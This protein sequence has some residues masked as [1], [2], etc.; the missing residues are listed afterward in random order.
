MHGLEYDIGMYTKLLYPKV[1]N[2]ACT[3]LNFSV[4]ECY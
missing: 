1:N 4:H 3:L 2:I